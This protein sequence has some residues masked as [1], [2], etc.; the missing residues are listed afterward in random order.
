VR[1]FR[2]TVGG[3]EVEIKSDAEEDTMGDL[4]SRALGALDAT[5]LKADEM[6]MGFE[7]QSSSGGSTEREP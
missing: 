1:E 6:V 7:G 3:H 4:I 2:L 5:K